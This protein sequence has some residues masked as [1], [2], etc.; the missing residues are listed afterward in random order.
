[1]SVPSDTLLLDLGNTHLHWRCGEAEGVIAN[2]EA[3]REWPFAGATVTRV[4]WSAVGPVKRLDALHQNLQHATWQ[5]CNRPDPEL[6]P[7]RYESGQLGID[8]WLAVLGA[9]AALKSG[10]TDCI[11][12]VAGTALTL[13]ILAAGV[14]IGGWIMPGYHCW[15]AG[16]YAGTEISSAPLDEARHEPGTSTA[17]AIA[18]GWQLAMTSAVET[19]ASRF[20]GAEVVLSGGDAGRLASAFPGAHRIPELVLD[21]LSVWA[22]Q[23]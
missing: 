9:Q 19:Q 21:G 6:L 13:D 8:R 22:T 16:L 15:H 14:H 23:V 1:M 12:V 17:A 2:P 7:T 3:C 4:C 20:P 5:R 11:V 10:K 18:N